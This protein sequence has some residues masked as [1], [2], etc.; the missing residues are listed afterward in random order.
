M[1]R[2]VRT[3]LCVVVPATLLL[4]GADRDAHAH[5]T[6]YHVHKTDKNCPLK[7][8]RADFAKTLIEDHD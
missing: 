2:S 7:D 1:K 5:H 8:N 6:R 3:V 4:G